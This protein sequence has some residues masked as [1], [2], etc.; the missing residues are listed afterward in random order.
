MD[1]ITNILHI[2]LN[3]LVRLVELVVGF[4]MAALQ[5]LLDFVRSLAGSVS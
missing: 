4:L 3:F 1:A 2:L 5:L